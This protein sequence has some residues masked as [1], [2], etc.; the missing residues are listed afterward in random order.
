[1]A[2]LGK[3]ICLSKWVSQRFWPTG[4]A[5]LALAN[6]CLEVGLH[7]NNACHRQW[8]RLR[9]VCLLSSAIASLSNQDMSLV[10]YT[11]KAQTGL[12]E[13]LNE[14]VDLPSFELLKDC[15]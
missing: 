9:R 7:G 6:W 8:Y 13:D 4:K 15:L 12:F 14:R 11:T 2:A 10:V 1:M 3:P 5:E